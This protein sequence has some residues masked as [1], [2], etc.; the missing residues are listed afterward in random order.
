MATVVY[1]GKS[2]QQLDA[3]PPPVRDAFRRAIRDLELSPQVLPQFPEIPLD[4]RPL[5]APFPLFRIAVHRPRGD[6][7]YRGVYSVEGTTVL[8]VRFVHRDAATYKG[9]RRTRGLLATRDASQEGV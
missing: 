6:P 3:L 5:E 9:V 4:T 8:F 7:G 2:R 1:L